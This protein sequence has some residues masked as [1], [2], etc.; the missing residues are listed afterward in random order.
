MPNHER[1]LY[2]PDDSDNDLR[3]DIRATGMDG[4]RSM[5]LEVEIWRTGSLLDVFLFLSSLLLFFGS[6]PGTNGVGTGFYHL[7]L[8]VEFP[9]A[10]DPPK[11]RH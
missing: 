3:R 8:E 11:G 2:H 1:K 10:P 7:L 9:R 6:R 4:R 5:G